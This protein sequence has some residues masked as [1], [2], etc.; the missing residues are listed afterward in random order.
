[1]AEPRYLTFP[2]VPVRSSFL[3]ALSFLDFF[4]SQNGYKFFYTQVA[5]ISSMQS[6]M[7]TKAFL[8][9]VLAHTMNLQ[10]LVARSFAVPQGDWP[11]SMIR[12]CADREEWWQP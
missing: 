5:V 6:K 3:L 12:Y 11:E 4:S 7:P 1:M 9:L 2:D 8:E 10:K